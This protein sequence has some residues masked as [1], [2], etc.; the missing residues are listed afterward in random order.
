MEVDKLTKEEMIKLMIDWAT[1]HPGEKWF[2]VNSAAEDALVKLCEDA[3]D[4][5]GRDG[6]GGC[7]L[8]QS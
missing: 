5:I 2:A 1:A 3:L 4:A 6:W 7:V 8:C